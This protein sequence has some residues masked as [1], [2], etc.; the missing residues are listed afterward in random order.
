VTVAE[1]FALNLQRERRRA[2]YSQ[3]Q[4]ANLAGLHRTEHL[5][6]L[7]VGSGYRGSTPL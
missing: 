5:A 2:G 1:R 7:S 3:E 6:I 4:L